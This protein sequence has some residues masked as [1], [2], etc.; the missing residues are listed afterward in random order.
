MNPRAAAR[1]IRDALP[2]KRQA[3]QALRSVWSPPQSVHRHLTFQGPF[4]VR[5]GR[6]SFLIDHFGQQVENSLFWAGYG[7]GYEGTSLLLWAMLAGHSRCILDIGA[8][9]GV[10]ALAAA[11]V[12]PSASVHAFEPIERIFRRI[13]RNVALNGFPIHCHQVALSD[14]AGTL[15]MLDSDSEHEY[16]ASFDAVMF[17]DCPSVIRQVET[18]RL[19]SYRLTPD[20]IKID[21]ERHEPA[22]LRGMDLANRPT[23]LI[24]ILDAAIG[25]EVEAIV[26]PQQYDF[27]RVDELRGIEPTHRL[28]GGGNFLLLP[29][30]TDFPRGMTHDAIRAATGGAPP[31]RRR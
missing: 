2:F 8:N 24:E 27:Y 14:Q 28:E 12:N 23:I 15:P 7:G 3:F 22:V 11:A 26:A 4:R 21:V 31:Q 10:Y 18:R 5:A 13:E 25:A 16:S 17:R 1:T 19:D 29:L 6:S 20:L 9:T 30:H